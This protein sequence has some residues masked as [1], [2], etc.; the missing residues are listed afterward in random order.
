MGVNK[1]KSEPI[2]YSTRPVSPSSY[3][4]RI[5]L[6]KEQ[7]CSSCLKSKFIPSWFF[8]PNLSKTHTYLWTRKLC[9]NFKM[10]PC[11]LSVN[12]NAGILFPAP[13]E[14]RLY[15]DIFIIYG[16][17]SINILRWAHT[18]SDC[19]AANRIGFLNGIFTAC[20]HCVVEMVLSAGAA[21]ILLIYSR[22]K[23]IL[24]LSQSTSAQTF[25]H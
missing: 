15:T 17:D 10:I 3:K 8:I 18:M 7:K 16:K 4:R 1:K 22:I 2:K 23:S 5:A 21:T 14:Y 19:R 24:V 12:E 25:I 20:Y 9:S 11:I 6:L 13:F